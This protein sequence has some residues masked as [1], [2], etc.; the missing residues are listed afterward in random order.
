MCLCMKYEIK[1]DLRINGIEGA[2]ILMSLYT[3]HPRVS[4][5]ASLS[6]LRGDPI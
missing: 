5:L 1:R 6:I 2:V 3:Q 4:I